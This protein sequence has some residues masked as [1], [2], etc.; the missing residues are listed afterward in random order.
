MAVPARK[1]SKS[2]KAKRRTHKKLSITGLNE[3]PNC[4]EMKKATMYVQIAAIMTV[5]T[6]P[7]QKKHN[8]F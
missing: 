5:K 3:C 7:Q 4:G 6:L 2:R 8:T 1:T